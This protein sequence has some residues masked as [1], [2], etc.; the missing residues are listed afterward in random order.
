VASKVVRLVSSPT[1]AVKPTPVP[2]M[3]TADLRLVAVPMSPSMP[4][5]Q[6]SI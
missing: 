5:T 2:G 1:N 3:P 6:R 4:S